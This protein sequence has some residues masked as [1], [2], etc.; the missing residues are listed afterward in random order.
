MLSASAMESSVALALE[1]DSRGLVI[2]PKTGS[3]LEQLC[4]ASGWSTEHAD[5]DGESNYRPNLGLAIHMAD[6]GPALDPVN[7]G[8]VR[9]SEHSRI[10]D[11]LVHQLAGAVRNQIHFARTVVSPAVSEFAERLQTYLSEMTPNQL[12]GIE[13]V[14]RQAPLPLMNTSLQDEIARYTEVS[15]GDLPTMRGLPADVDGDFLRN[16]LET[17]SK[18]LDEDIQVW[19]AGL[20]EDSLYEAWSFLRDGGV[21]LRSYVTNSRS[22]ENGALLIWLMATKLFDNPPEGVATPLHLYNTDLG[23]IRDQM[24]AILF[25]V[26]RR[27]ARE[28]EDGVLVDAVEGKTVFVNSIVYAVFIEKGG[29]NDAL[30]GNLALSRPHTRL[31]SILEAQP[32]L[33]QSWQRQVAILKSTEEQTRY[34]N[35]L[36]YARSIFQSMYNDLPAEQRARLPQVSRLLELFDETLRKATIESTKDLHSFGL[37]LLGDS[38]FCLSD[39]K[40]I[41]QG[42]DK[43]VKAN[44]GLE[45]REAASLA[46]MDYTNSWLAKQ[47]TVRPV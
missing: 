37:E 23:I 26:V 31:E 42:I 16:L 18:T 1:A 13:I 45:P 3:P 5:A 21:G 2:V 12:L 4:A 39:A 46:Q 22:G 14:Q 27:L 7:E 15:F 24:G 8:D 10:Q 33:I 47:L 28:I 40:E 36:R 11:Y 25:G 43:A 38:I 44:P 30:F 6:A 20:G 35:T 34:N 17:G 32:Q 41:L 19:A 29:D 9:I